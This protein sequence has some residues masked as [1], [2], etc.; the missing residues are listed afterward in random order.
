M[1][2]L[3]EIED[4]FDI[5]GRGYVLVPGVPDAF[6]RD[7]KT[8]E[9]LLIVTPQGAYVRTNVAAFEMISRGRPMVHAPFSLPRAVNKA[10]LP[11]GS[12]VYLLDAT[13]V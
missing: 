13:D 6:R 4:V 1:Q 11:V 9:Q 3:F 7:V 2:F 12:K 8:G 5:G 10:S